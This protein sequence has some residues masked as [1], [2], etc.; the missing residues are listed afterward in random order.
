MK[1]FLLLALLIV[2]AFGS[3]AQYII[4]MCLSGDCTNG[5]GAAE[6]KSQFMAATLHYQ[7]A[8]KNGKMD[9]EG[10]LA[11]PAEYYVGS[12]EDGEERGYGILFKSKAVAGHYVPD[13]SQWVSFCK[14]DDDGGMKSEQIREDGSITFFNTEGRAKHKSFKPYR[15]VKDSWIQEHVAAYLAAQQIA[16]AR[17][18]AVHD[19]LFPPQVIRDPHMALHAQNRINTARGKVE[20]LISWDCTSARKYY[21]TASNVVRGKLTVMPFGGFVRYQVRSEDDKVLWE[22]AVDQYWHPEK[23]GRY[24]FLIIFDANVIGG[25][26]PDGAYLEWSLRSETL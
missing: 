15:E 18:K 8:F 23:D 20:R 13:S 4:L 22:G 6:C 9:G 19:S 2:P 1:K 16:F 21:V 10:T 3:N 25:N 12:F 14:W 24:N 26:P 11:G 7:G 5:I 17:R